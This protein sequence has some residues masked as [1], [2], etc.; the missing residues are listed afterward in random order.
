MAESQFDLYTFCVQQKIKSFL[1]SNSKN[2]DQTVRTYHI[3][4][5]LALQVIYHSA[6]YFFR[7]FTTV[8]LFI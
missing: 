2:T 4:R 3:V 6:A 7:Y 1:L 8:M 5:F